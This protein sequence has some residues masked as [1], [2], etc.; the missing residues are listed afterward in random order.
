MNHKMLALVPVEMKVDI[1]TKD[2]SQIACYINMLISAKE[3]RD[4]V[5]VGIII[6]QL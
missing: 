2:Y 4:H 5:M 1:D 6:L 3:V